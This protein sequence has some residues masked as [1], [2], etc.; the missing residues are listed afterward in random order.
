[1]PPHLTIAPEIVSWSERRRPLVHLIASNDG[2][3]AAGLFAVDL[4]VAFLNSADR[5]QEFA[6]FSYEGTRRAKVKGREDEVLS[7]YRY[8]WDHPR[9]HPLFRGIREPITKGP[10]ELPPISLQLFVIEVLSPWAAPEVRA[11]QI[12]EK[13]PVELTLDQFEFVEGTEVP[14]FRA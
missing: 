8:Y 10:V 2:D 5:K 4:Y 7:R 14:A 1:V 9:R 13:A 11:Y 12:G 3:G 6:E